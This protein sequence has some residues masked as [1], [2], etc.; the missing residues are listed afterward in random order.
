MLPP[1]KYCTCGLS[2]ENA[3]LT[4][5]EDNVEVHTQHSVV[6]HSMSDVLYDFL[7]LFAL[8]RKNLQESISLDDV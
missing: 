2:E 6:M 1:M 4:F 3:I 7:L 8:S 5:G